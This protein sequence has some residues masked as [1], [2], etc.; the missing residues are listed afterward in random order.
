MDVKEALNL[1]GQVCAGYK[2]TLQEHQA[3]QSALKVINDKCSEL[4]TKQ[5]VKKK[6]EV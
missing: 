3:L 2:G 5:V 1:L 4:N 6:D